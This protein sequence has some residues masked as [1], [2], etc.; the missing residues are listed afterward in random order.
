[1]LRLLCLIIYYSDPFLLE[2]K[3]QQLQQNQKFV[4]V[5]L[6]AVKDIIKQRKGWQP[7]KAYAIEIN[8]TD[9]EDLCERGD[10]DGIGE[11]HNMKITNEQNIQVNEDLYTYGSSFSETYNNPNGLSHYIWAPIKY[12]PPITVSSN[13]CYI[14]AAPEN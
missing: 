12:V 10:I 7:P 8:S 5:R 3:V 9:Y 1:M 4:L 11:D 6:G 14:W 2:L 13:E